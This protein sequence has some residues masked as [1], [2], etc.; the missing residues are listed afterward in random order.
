MDANGFFEKVNESANWLEKKIP[1]KPEAVVVL[2]GGLSKFLDPLTEKIEISSS[3][4]PHFPR[5]KAEGHSGKI[6]FGKLG[7]ARLAVLQGRFHYYEGHTPQAVV[8]PYFVFNKIGARFLVTTNAVG[9]INKNFKPGDIMMIRDHINFMGINPLIGI[10]VQRPTQQF[11]SMTDAYS[12]RLR[13]IA[14]RS[15]K[16]AGVELK[17][18][19]FIA[20]SGPSYECKAEIS[21]F[22]QW[23]ADAVGMSTVPEVIAANFLEMKVASFS[24]IANPASDLHAGT[25]THAEVLDA[26]NKLSGNAV[27]LLDQFIKDMTAEKLIGL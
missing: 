4:I 3:E 21:A 27:K 10:S 8:F 1:F 9:G 26:M 13:E 16:A 6:I 18:G 24:C 17:E 11:T 2:S 19:V 25:M 12:S 7:N 22:R 15:A 20:T 14:T 5:A 23:G